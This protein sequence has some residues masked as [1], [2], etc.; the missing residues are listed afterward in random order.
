MRTTPIEECRH[1]L[2]VEPGEEPEALIFTGLLDTEANDGTLVRLV[3]T[4]VGAGHASPLR[5]DLMRDGGMWRIVQP[6]DSDPDATA[7]IPADTAWRVFNKGIPKSEAF[8][9]STLEGD[10]S[11]AAKVFDTVSLIA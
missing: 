2:G 11:L 3:I 5:Y 6:L 1:C 7:T 8:A 9:L 4:A 10:P